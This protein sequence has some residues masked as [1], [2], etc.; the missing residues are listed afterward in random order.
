MRVQ[1]VLAGGGG[2]A[3]FL[4]HPQRNSNNLYVYNILEKKVNRVT[5]SFQFPANAEMGMAHVGAEFYV[6]GGYSG[7]YHDYFHKFDTEGETTKLTNMPKTKSWF[8]LVHSASRDCLF[9]VGGYSNG[10]NM[11]ETTQYLITGEKW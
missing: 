1:L 11:N 8:P 5:T 2:E 9:T 4:F 10:G 3:P 6:A 7:N